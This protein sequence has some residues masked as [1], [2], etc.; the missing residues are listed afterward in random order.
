MMAQLTGDIDTGCMAYGHMT[1]HFK[2]AKSLIISF[3]I[4]DLRNVITCMIMF[5]LIH[6]T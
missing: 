4:R 3:G 5:M 2:F 1:L 6:I